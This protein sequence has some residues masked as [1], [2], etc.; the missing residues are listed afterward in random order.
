MQIDSFHHF[1]SS[2]KVSNEYD[3]FIWLVDWVAKDCRSSVATH[4]STTCDD[5]VA[6]AKSRSSSGFL[7]KFW[8]LKFSICYKSTC[9]KNALISA[10]VKCIIY[11]KVKEQF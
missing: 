5:W 7:E 11:N 10:K 2:L 3:F 9:F 4:R 6:K 1:L 8:N